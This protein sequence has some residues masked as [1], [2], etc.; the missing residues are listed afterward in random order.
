LENKTHRYSAS[1]LEE[2]IDFLGHVHHANYLVLFEQARWDWITKNGYGLNK[3]LATKI[4][5]VILEL[6]IRYRKELRARQEIT[7][8]SQVTSHHKLFTDIRQVMKNQEGILCSEIQL[9]FGCFNLET[10]KLIAPPL[11]WL[12]AL[13]IINADQ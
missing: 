9:K 3:I 11:E 1:I 5:P 13:D 4:G 6:D 7:I 10:R 2:Y 8:E 12:Q